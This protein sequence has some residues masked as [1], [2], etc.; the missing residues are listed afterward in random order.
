MSCFDNL[1][2]RPEY[3]QA[4]IRILEAA[5]AAERA[6]GEQLRA[7]I[8]CWY[9][10]LESWIGEYRVCSMDHI[11]VIE[12]ARQLLKRLHIET[13]TALIKV[14]ALIPDP[15]AAGEVPR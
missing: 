12:H 10:R 14:R 7:Y 9:A 2:D 6:E 8:Q 5:L 15:G 13:R 11:G 3:L 1:Q 4:K